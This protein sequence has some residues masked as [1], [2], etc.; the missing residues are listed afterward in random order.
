MFFQ[1]SPE[2]SLTSQ[3]E[4]FR[5]M[6]CMSPFWIPF[7]GCSRKTRER[8]VQAAPAGRG[9]ITIVWNCWHMMTIK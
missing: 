4:E 5:F 7:L 6:S 8:D 9:I 1:F 2:K 3:V